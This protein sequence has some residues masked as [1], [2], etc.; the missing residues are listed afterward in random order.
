MPAEAQQTLINT[1]FKLDGALLPLT[2]HRVLYRHQHVQINEIVYAKKP[3]ATLYEPEIL[4]QNWPGPDRSRIGEIG[5]ADGK[6]EW[7]D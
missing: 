2:N 3:P 7:A 5:G 4:R 1:M 6:S